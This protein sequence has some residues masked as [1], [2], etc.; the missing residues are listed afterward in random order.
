MCVYPVLSQ[1]ARV[2]RVDILA[3]TQHFTGDFKDH[4][5][6]DFPGGDRAGRSD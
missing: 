3:V 6:S 4:P 2:H 5:D 1:Y